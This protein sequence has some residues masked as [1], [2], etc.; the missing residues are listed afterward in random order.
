[1]GEAMNLHLDDKKLVESLL[2]SRG[3]LRILEVL[4]E[5]GELNHS[6]I[7]RRVGSARRMI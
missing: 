2:G 3:R 6:Q 7:C 1:M 5:S 4:A